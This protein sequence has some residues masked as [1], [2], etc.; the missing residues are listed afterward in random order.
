MDPMHDQPKVSNELTRQRILTLH[1]VWRDEVMVAFANLPEV[2]VNTAGIVVNGALMTYGMRSF[3]K[4]HELFLKR[5]PVTKADQGQSYHNYGLAF[6]FCLQHPDGKISWSLKED[7]DGDGKKDWEEVARH[8]ESY[9]WDWGGDW[10]GF[11][12]N[13]HIEFIP[14]SIKAIAQARGVRAWRVLRELHDAG[15]LDDKGFVLIP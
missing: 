15:T 3:A 8:F 5:P 11:R 6:D 9:G 12:D 2:L 14:P 4:Q 1:P 7:L 10:D 13:P